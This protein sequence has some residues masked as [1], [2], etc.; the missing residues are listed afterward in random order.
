MLTARKVSLVL[1]N[2]PPLV[3]VYLSRRNL[4]TLLSKLDRKRLGEQTSCTIV[5]KDTLHATHP[6]SHPLV[7]VMAVEDSEYYADREPGAVLPKDLPK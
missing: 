6:Q 4:L 1:V 2:P 3:K 7:E 5:K